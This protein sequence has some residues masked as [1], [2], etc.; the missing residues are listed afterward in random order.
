M[1]G[2]KGMN[3]IGR[4]GSLLFLFVDSKHIGSI[5]NDVLDKCFNLFML[6]LSPIRLDTRKAKRSDPLDIVIVLSNKS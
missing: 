6:C 4:E 1:G 3:E 5:D 2:I